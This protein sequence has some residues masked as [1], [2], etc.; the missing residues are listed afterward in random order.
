MQESFADIQRGRSRIKQDVTYAITLWK[1]KKCLRRGRKAC[2]RDI[3][4][5]FDLEIG[6]CKHC[7][8]SGVVR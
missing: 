7:Q 2:T 4:Q 6:L 3:K 1:E 8:E 5:L